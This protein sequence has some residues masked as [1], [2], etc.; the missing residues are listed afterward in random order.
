M[1]NLRTRS[2][3]EPKIESKEEL[4]EK[5]VASLKEKLSLKDKDLTK[6]KNDV[7][8]T[9]A[10]MENLRT[11]S[12]RDNKQI[13]EYAIQSFAKS[14]L[15]VADNLQLAVKNSQ[16]DVEKETDNKSLKVLFE[17]ITLT[18][19]TLKKAFEKQKIS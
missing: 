15:E 1:E 7:L 18:E 13:R 10:D 6:A 3:Q 8:R 2:Q 9:L 5:E 17:G 11:R 12:Q 4:L 16:A 19:K 14:L